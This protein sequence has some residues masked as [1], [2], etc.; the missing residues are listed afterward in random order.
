MKTIT[1]VLFW[2]LSVQVFAQVSEQTQNKIVRAILNLD[3]VANSEVVIVTLNLSDTSTSNLHEK[4]IF[5][6]GKSPIIKSKITEV[7]ASNYVSI[8]QECKGFDRA[9]FSFFYSA[10]FGNEYD[11]IMRTDKEK[12]E[13]IYELIGNKK[14][15]VVPPKD[16]IFFSRKY[17]TNCVPPDNLNM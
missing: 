7:L 4:M 9:L 17:R 10:D 3:S 8:A 1:F 6:A 16:F 2:F 5:L 15:F 13:K 14:V 11:Y 12:I